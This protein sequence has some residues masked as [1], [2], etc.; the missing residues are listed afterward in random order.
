MDSDERKHPPL[1]RR[2]S[3][4]LGSNG[5]PE[6]FQQPVS[7]QSSEVYEKGG[8]IKKVL[9]SYAVDGNHNMLAI[10]EDK[11]KRNARGSGRV[12]VADFTPNY[13]YGGQKIPIPSHLP[14]QNSIHM[15]QYQQSNTIPG[16]AYFNNGHSDNHNVNNNV[17]NNSPHGGGGGWCPG[18]GNIDGSPNGSNAGDR[19]GLDDRVQG[20][21]SKRNKSIDG[22]PLNQVHG[23]F[24]D[25][26]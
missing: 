14:M 13:T 24:I 1:M 26:V 22:D 3:L 7:A 23:H 20:Y 12:N 21:N 10:P 6:S 25:F 16:N 15:N 9:D 8:Y 2:L 17:N 4:P 11:K 5:V 18:F 19:I